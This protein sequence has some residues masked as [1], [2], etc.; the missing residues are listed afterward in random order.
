MVIFSVSVQCAICHRKHDVLANSK[1]DIPSLSKYKKRIENIG[2]KE[3]DLGNNC[4]E[5][6]CNQCINLIE[7]KKLTIS[8]GD[9]G[10]LEIRRG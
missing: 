1:S 4:M 7:N 9:D 6:I 5:H 10:C 2:W 3:M 8:F